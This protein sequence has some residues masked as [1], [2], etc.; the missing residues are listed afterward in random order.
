MAEI[1]AIIAFPIAA[2]DTIKAFIK[3]GRALHQQITDYKNAPTAVLGVKAFAQS[4]YDGALQQQILTAEWMFAQ[5]DINETVKSEVSESLQQLK[6]ELLKIDSYIANSFDENKE[7]RRIDYTLKYSKKIAA[8]MKE[9]VTWKTEFWRQVSI[10]DMMRRNIPDP[11]LLTKQNYAP[12]FGDYGQHIEESCPLTQGKTE[13][14]DK[15]DLREITVLVEAIEDKS[16]EGLPEAKEI[17]AEIAQKLSNGNRGILRCLGYRT[18]PAELVFA[19]PSS[20][21]VPH[22]LRYHLLRN[23][24][25]SC[26]LDYR[27]RLAQEIQEAV[28]SVNAAKFVHKNIR[29][30]TIVLFSKASQPPQPTQPNKSRL[31]DD[32]LLSPAYLTDWNMLHEVGAP[33]Y[34]HGDKEWDRNFYRHYH[35][36][37]TKPQKRYQIKYDIYSLGVC[38]LE[39]GLWESFVV[40]DPKSK[41]AQ[42]SD[43]FLTAAVEHGGAK[44]DDFKNLEPLCASKILQE[45]LVGIA[46]QLLPKCMGRAFTKLVVACL[47]NVEGGFGDEKAFEGD[48]I[49]AALNLKNLILEASPRLS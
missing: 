14:K 46:E 6:G 40:I 38:L 11:L 17:A 7:L 24:D 49:I 2:H 47:T 15:D 23:N 31:L 39:I 37:G 28:F 44:E 16:Q 20:F 25:Y 22:T 26:T 4:L 21:D 34:R 30:D 33:S 5:K 36:Q 43:F 12:Q 1:L 13:F 3:Y 29:P 19:F 9:I 42:L 8:S 45:M 18:S 10:I 48:N 32:S 27:F 41:K 35:R